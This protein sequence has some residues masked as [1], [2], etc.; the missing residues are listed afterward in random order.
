MG[1]FVTLSD[2]KEQT[3][4][5]QV[6]NPDR[7]FG[8]FVTLSDLKE[9]PSK[10][11]RISGEEDG[12]IAID[13]RRKSGLVE[14]IICCYDSGKC[15]NS[16]SMKLEGLVCALGAWFCRDC[17][18]KVRARA[19][20]DLV[21]A[22]ALGLWALSEKDLEIKA[23]DMKIKHGSKAVSR[24]RIKRLPPAM[25]IRLMYEKDPKLPRVSRVETAAPPTP[26][27][28]LA[29]LSIQQLRDLRLQRLE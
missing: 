3:T 4:K 28:F 13:K 5:E 1:I 21:Y 26:P 25:L 12:S 9:Q 11:Q 29:P 8:R 10:K 7:P 24:E 23:T 16:R 18:E 15:S 27:T 14:E 22:N 6:G 20:N 19:A 17:H 2:L